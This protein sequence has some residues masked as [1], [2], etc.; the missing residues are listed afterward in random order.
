MKSVIL[1][2]TH[3]HTHTIFTVFKSLALFSHFLFLMPS[4]SEIDNTHDQK[5]DEIQAQ[6]K[7]PDNSAASD[8]GETCYEHATQGC[9]TGDPETI[10]IH[11][12]PDYPDCDFDLIVTYCVQYAGNSTFVTVSDY[13]WA[14]INQIS[15]D[16]PDFWH[17]Y[18]DIYLNGTEGDILEFVHRIDK[19]IYT[20]LEDYFFAEFGTGINCNSLQEGT[21]VLSFIK[22]S[23]YAVC[24]YREEPISVGGGLSP[25]KGN[26]KAG[27]RG[28]DP[29]YFYVKN[30]CLTDGCCRRETRICF[31]PDTNTLEKSTTLSEFLLGGGSPLCDENAEIE[32]NPRY[33]N[34]TLVSCTRCEFSCQE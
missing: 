28:P 31:N 4:C 16:C 29:I 2:V 11:G 8:F 5:Q 3:T 9:D 26:N 27:N 30:I 6:R 24:T 7:V 12:I 20:R 23:C 10:P 17:D 22:A 33:G 21:F 15:E 13:D 1:G 25:L 19:Q 14:N 34:N 18:S 32:L